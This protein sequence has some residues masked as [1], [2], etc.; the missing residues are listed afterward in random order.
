MSDYITGE[1]LDLPHAKYHALPHHSRSDLTLALRSPAHLRAAK[2]APP[3]VTPAMKLG[4]AVHAAVLTPG[5]FDDEVAYAPEGN[6]RTKAGK[7]E[8]DA[9]MEGAANKTVLPR[10]DK[11]AVDAIVEAVQAS[12]AAQLLLSGPDRREAS[13]MWMDKQTGLPCR[14]RPD[15]YI[16]DRKMIVDLKTTKDARPDAF[17][18]AVFDHD[19]HVQAAYY[20]DGVNAA[21]GDG[22]ATSFV[23]LAVEKEPP[24]G[25]LV[26]ALDAEDLERGRDAY[27]RGL[28]RIR[29]CSENDRW[30]GYSSKVHRLC[31]PGWAR[32][33]ID[34]GNA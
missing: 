18:R 30:P 3:R 22:A 26:G 20:L 8:Y 24:Y 11:A 16:P 17:G 1:V 31:L 32:K 27:R 29:W 2:D 10:S 7:E 5:L 4:T 34:Q 6:R 14:C 12:P 28:N 33:R 15:I 13:Y 21:L 19:Y 25:V 23:F 9:F